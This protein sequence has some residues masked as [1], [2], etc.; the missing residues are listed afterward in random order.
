[1]NRPPPRSTRTDTLFP[2]T[3]LFRSRH[4]RREAR[5][6]GRDSR[7]REILEHRGDADR[8]GAAAEGAPD[9]ADEI[10]EGVGGRR[11]NE[12]AIDVEGDEVRA[13]VRRSDGGQ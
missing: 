1:M 9:H 10:A 3:T 6:E 8:V 2:Y 12:L 4:A 11:R 7:R 5:I 13:L